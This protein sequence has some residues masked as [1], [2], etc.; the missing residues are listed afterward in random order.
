MIYASTPSST[1]SCGS[2][3]TPTPNPVQAKGFVFPAPPRQPLWGVK[4]RDVQSTEQALGPMYPCPMPST[5]THWVT[6]RTWPRASSRAAS[7]GGRQA[8]R[9]RASWVDTQRRWHGAVSAVT[10]L[11]GLGTH[12]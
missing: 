10:I 7:G 5:V 4:N 2:D 11:E 1:G 9:R 8:G 3:V 6:N 12:G